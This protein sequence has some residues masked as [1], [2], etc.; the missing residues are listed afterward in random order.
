MR[1][2]ERL[3]SREQAR[4]GHLIEALLRLWPP[5]GLQLFKPGGSPPAL[6]FTHGGGKLAVST[7][8]GLVSLWDPVTGKIVGKVF[9]HGSDV[10][11]L[12]VDRDDTMLVTTSRKDGRTRFWDLETAQLEGEL[13]IDS[14]DS[15]RA[16]AVSSEVDVVAAL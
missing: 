2:Q 14:A 11:A 6:A 10:D 3:R 8:G 7:D 1:H 16:V 12:A 13:R 5:H 15:L 4:A 9:L